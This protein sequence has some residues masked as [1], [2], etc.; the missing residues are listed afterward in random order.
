MKIK[1][2]ITSVADVFMPRTCSVCGKPLSLDEPFLCRK[3]M[4]EIP[5]T[6]YEEIDFN[7]FDQLMA[8]KVPV[9]R[10]ASSFFYQKNDP[11]AS[12]TSSTTTCQLWADGLQNA[13]PEK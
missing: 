5:R 12:T 7:P 2:L 13:L 6:H 11:Y 8:G 1:D 9:E 4:M 10:C 3:C